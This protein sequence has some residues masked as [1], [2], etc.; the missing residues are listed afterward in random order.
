MK[1][2]LKRHPEDTDVTK[3]FTGDY[4]EDQAVKT[5]LE[6]FLHG[7]DP[8]TNPSGKLVELHNSLGQPT[9]E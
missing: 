7:N 8:A 6:S 5:V 2:I 3:K 4:V 9:K 1:E